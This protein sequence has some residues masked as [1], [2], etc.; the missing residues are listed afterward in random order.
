MVKHLDSHPLFE[1]IPNESDE[2]KND[3]CVK[4]VLTDTE[5]GKKVERN[6]GDKFLAVYRRVE[7]KEATSAE[8]LGGSGWLGFEVTKPTPGGEDGGGRD[9]KKSKK[10][11]GDDHI[12][13]D[14]DDEEEDK[15]DVAE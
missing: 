10:N 9:E 5:E 13:E 2:I 6:K 4:C 1:R 8:N 12:E 11:G 3:V 7:Y 14:D 15:E